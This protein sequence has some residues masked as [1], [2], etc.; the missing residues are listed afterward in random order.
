MN[1]LKLYQDHHIPYA[2]PGQRHYREG[3]LNTTCPFCSG[4]NPGN[5]LGYCLDPK[6]QFYGAYVCFRCGGKGTVRTVAKLLGTTDPQASIIVAQYGGVG[7]V[8]VPQ[9]LPREERPAV[10]RSISL[11]PNTMELSKCQGALRYLKARRFDPEELSE[12]WGVRATTNGAVVETGKWPIKYSFRLIIPIVYEGKVVSY[13][14]RDW[15]NIQQPKYLTCAKSVES[16]HHKDIL[17]GLDLARGMEEV[18]LVEGVT[19]VWRIGP[20]AVACFGIKYR[21]P[22]MLE[23]VKR[24]KRVTVFFDPEPQ[25][26]EQARK[27]RNEL[28]MRGVEVRMAHPPKGRDPADLTEDEVKELL[29]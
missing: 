6:S 24:F 17:Y 5:H 19:D 22:Q 27:I 28:Q 10:I 11:P 21:A 4:S 2:S 9:R 14:G 8:V 12:R 29:R 18:I 13:Q 23:L 16:V 3:W 1:A 25:A 26:K 20:G 7:P 15:T